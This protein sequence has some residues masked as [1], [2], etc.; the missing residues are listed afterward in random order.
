MVAVWPGMGQVA[1][2]AGFYLMSKLQMHSEKAPRTTDLF[3]LDHLEV[4]DGL[5]KAGH[6]P[7]SHLFAASDSRK[8]SRLG[9]MIGEAQPSMHA[10]EY[11]HRILDRAAK[12][13]VGQ[14]FTFA[15]IAIDIHPREPSRVLGV[16]TSSE[17]LEILQ[18]HQ[19]GVLEAGQITGM[20]GIFLAAAAERG[21]P[22]I[23][24]LGVIPALASR[25]PY[26]K[27]SHAV[28]EAFAR[29]ADLDLDLGELEEY[30]RFIDEKLLV[31]IKR[32]MEAIEQQAG[33][34]TPPFESDESEHPGMPPGSPIPEPDRRKIE[35]LFVQAANDRSKAFELKRELDRMD[36]FG[37][38]ENR[39]L[40]LF[41]K[42]R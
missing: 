42:P 30:G 12:L 32:L 21:I 6:L 36:L 19:I 15:A 14:V 10:L 18:R 11:C 17:G 3:D 22:G 27:A 16:A 13:G 31:G 37:E 5:A 9:L 25:I 24:L 29:V 35:E 1:L 20:N 34:G 2:T 23:C 26:P 8:H 28:L 33:E 7:E 39:F 38:Y 4:S 41:R 40:D